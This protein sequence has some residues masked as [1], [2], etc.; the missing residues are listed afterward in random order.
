MRMGQALTS[1]IVVAFSL[2]VSACAQQ[3]TLYSWG[4]YQPS[5]LGYYKNSI[6]AAKFTENLRITIEKAEATNGKVPPGLY[7]EYG[8]ELLETG[9]EQ[10]ALL[11]FAKE[12]KN[13]P[14]AAEFMDRIAER[15][16]QK[17]GTTAEPARPQDPAKPSS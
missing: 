17:P 16:T 5:L 15:L 8:F 6:D 9:N 13:W 3:P 2:L 7:A 4:N 10:Q 14:E 12:K 11:M 1:K